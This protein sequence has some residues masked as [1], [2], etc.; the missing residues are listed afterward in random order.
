MA[1][2]LAADGAAWEMVADAQADPYPGSAGPPAQDRRPTR[3]EG[4]DAE[5]QRRRR[6]QF[7]A[8]QRLELSHLPLRM[9]EHVERS[10][11]QAQRTR[12]SASPTAG[13]RRPAS[14]PVKAEGSVVRAE[15][16]AST[17]ATSPDPPARA[18]AWGA[19]TARGAGGARVATGWRTNSILEV[20]NDTLAASNAGLLG[21][22]AQ[23]NAEL[24]LL[25]R[26][27]VALR[28]QIK[29]SPQPLPAGLEAVVGRVIT[30]S[31]AGLKKEEDEA[32]VQPWTIAGWLRSIG[33]VEMISSHLCKRLRVASK[34]P[35]LERLF[36]AAL[37]NLANAAD[38]TP[39]LQSVVSRREL[40]VWLLREIPI[41][42]EMADAMD[43]AATRL[44]QESAEREQAA[45]ARRCDAGSG[46]S[47]AYVVDASRDESDRRE[48]LSRSAKEKLMAEGPRALA[49][50]QDESC[51]GARFDDGLEGIIGR[52]D[53]DTMRGLHNEHALQPDSMAYFDS[54][55]HGVRTSSLIE[56]CFVCEPSPE[57]LSELGLRSWPPTSLPRSPLKLS[58]VDEALQPVNRALAAGSHASFTREHFFALRLYTGPMFVKYKAVLRGLWPTAA[59]GAYGLEQL[60]MGNSYPTT[61]HAINDGIR[62]LSRLTMVSRVFLPLADGWLPPSFYS[63]GDAAAHRSGVECG[64]LTATTDYQAAREAAV[65]SE[66]RT[67]LELRM[68]SS[69]RGAHLAWLAQFDDFTD[70]LTFPPFTS[71][72]LPRLAAKGATAHPHRIDGAVVVLE[73]PVST[74]V[75]QR[76]LPQSGRLGVTPQ[77]SLP[78]LRAKLADSRWEWLSMISPP[79]NADVL[80]PR[81]YRTTGEIMLCNDGTVSRSWPVYDDI[82]NT[83][84]ENVEGR[85]TLEW[86]EDGQLQVVCSHLFVSRDAHRVTLDATL[87]HF[88]SSS[89]LDMG[90]RVSPLPGIPEILRLS[91]QAPVHAERVDDPPEV[92]RSEVIRN[93]LVSSRWDWLSDGANKRGEIELNEDGIMKASWGKSTR[94]KVECTEDGKVL[95]VCPRFQLS[96]DDALETFQCSTKGEKGV[97][98]T[99]IQGELPPVE[100][101]DLMANES[102][103][104][105]AGQHIHK[106]PP[107]SQYHLSHHMFNSMTALP[108]PALMFAKDPRGGIQNVLRSSA[109]SFE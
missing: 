1:P 75:S 10:Y 95:I 30:Q 108:P 58:D 22:L 46:A 107:A 97:R 33:V 87:T 102:R 59:A 51:V 89:T 24:A 78:V 83:H 7:E 2:L 29:G 73:L 85:W 80:T 48:D 31:V 64:C 4:T 23:L 28:R 62:H 16:D 43:K 38:C 109:N 100:P 103:F 94:W 36:I 41:V 90:R 35:R 6:L 105:S 13:T 69:D 53:A 98:T 93:L 40:L 74:R 25:K 63:R 81:A 37:G 50:F 17:G 14:A 68:G 82:L 49:V 42:E 96:L 76:A 65:R 88:T 101:A 45:E 79:P 106:G 12:K 32:T 44:A 72:E 9:Q 70:A 77:D 39:S 86:N 8:L 66:Q 84:L 5:R 60:C 20:Q 57:R 104:F 99:P 56:Y 67:L 54:A 34:D 27:N 26:D 21:R 91:A 61:L 18:A 3:R 15:H 11:L 19:V 55:A 92:S 71:V 52:G 47:T